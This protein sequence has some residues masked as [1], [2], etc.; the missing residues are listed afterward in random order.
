M[1]RGGVILTTRGGTG[2]GMCAIIPTTTGGGMAGARVGITITTILI[3]VGVPDT[4]HRIMEW[5][6][7]PITIRDTEAVR[8]IASR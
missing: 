1:E 3:G 7:R 5:A 8:L 6:V 2:T 4:T